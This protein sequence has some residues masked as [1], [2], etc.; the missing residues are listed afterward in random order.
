MSNWSDEYDYDTDYEEYLDLSENLKKKIC[1]KTE[2][3][4]MNKVCCSDDDIQ[5]GFLFWHS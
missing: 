3:Q 1:G 2:E 4:E 5:V